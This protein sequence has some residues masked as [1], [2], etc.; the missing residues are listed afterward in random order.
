MIYSD[1]NYTLSLLL[2]ILRTSLLRILFLA[3][4]TRVL[5]R[6]LMIAMDGRQLAV[7]T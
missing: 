3:E 7:L 1:L 5:F 2:S 4:H 6:P